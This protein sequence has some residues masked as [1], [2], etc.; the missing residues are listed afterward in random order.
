MAPRF[1]IWL[2]SSC[3]EDSEKTLITAAMLRSTLVA[4]INSHEN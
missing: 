1:F 4:A 3:S 2:I